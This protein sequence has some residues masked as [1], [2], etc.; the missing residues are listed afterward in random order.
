MRQSQP[1]TDKSDLAIGIWHSAYRYTSDS[2]RGL[3]ENEHF[4]RLERQDDGYYVESLPNDSKSR[5]TMRLKV[6]G[7]VATGT[8]R[9]QTSPDGYYKGALYHGAIQLVIVDS[10]QSLRGKWVGFGKNQTVN[11]G[12]WELTYVGRNLPTEYRL[13]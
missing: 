13:S 4:V 6:E 1:L 3:F 9:E 2:R 10:G 11:V 7:S 8:W 12:A 5:L